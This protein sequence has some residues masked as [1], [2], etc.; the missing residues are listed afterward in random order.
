M[1][2]F[3]IVKLQLRTED[4]SGIGSFKYGGRWNNEGVYAVY[5]C[6]H[7][8]LAILENLVHFEE[9]EFPENMFRMS[10]HLDDLAPVYTV[11]PTELPENW[12][13]PENTKLKQL[14]DR[15]LQSNQFIAIKCPSAIVPDSF[16][17]IL[18]PLFPGYHDLVKV[19]EVKK[20]ALDQR[21]QKKNG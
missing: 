13:I 11:L 1:L 19:V 9:S 15:I 3:R 7:E 18:N 5:S 16:N 20:I 6:E 12:R 14:G 4:L 10:I 17:Y 2:V 21:L 8:A